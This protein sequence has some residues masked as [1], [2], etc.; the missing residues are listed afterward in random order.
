M[1]GQQPHGLI[2]IY[3]GDGKGKTTAALGLALRA[4]GREQRVLMI[5]FIKRPGTAGEHRSAERLAPEFELKPMGTGFVHGEWQ[6][7]DRQ[8]AQEA[9]SVGQQAV[10]S[11]EYALVIFD[12]I[13]Y[14]LQAGVIPLE[15]VLGTLD[16]R[17]SHVHVLFTGREAPQP[18][19]HRA[20]LITEMKCLK[21]PHERGLKAQRGIEF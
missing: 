10:L 17:P 3:T 4:V 15:E 20:D 9:W 16:Q 11:G 6:E 12:E 18:L 14:V 8:A 5:Q 19:L 1:T 21:H 13:T 7:E 2:I